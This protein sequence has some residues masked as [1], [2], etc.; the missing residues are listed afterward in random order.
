MVFP[1]KINEVTELT[2]ESTLAMAKMSPS[3][4]FTFDKDIKVVFHFFL[5]LKFKIVFK[6]YWMSLFPPILAQFKVMHN[7]ESML[8]RVLPK[9]IE[10]A[11][12]C[13]QFEKIYIFEW[14]SKRALGVIFSV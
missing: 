14:K 5:L 8:V 12:Q 4:F 3:L 7:D 6:Y 13:M 11:L 9:L 2:T 1:K 10:N